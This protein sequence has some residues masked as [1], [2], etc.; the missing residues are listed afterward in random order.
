[1]TNYRIVP[2]GLKEFDYPQGDQNVYTKYAGH[3]GILLIVWKK[4]LLAWHQFDMR[5][6]FLLTCR[7]KVAFNCGARSSRVWCDLRPS[8]SSIATPYLVMDQGR[9]FWIQDAY[10]A[11]DG[12]PYSEPTDNGF[13]YIRNSVKIVV[14][15]Y[16]GDVDSYVVDP[17][18]PILR[19]YRAALPSPLPPTR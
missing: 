17:Q 14:D 5:S 19:V 12:F 1:M 8:L 11:A 18:D 4:A 15:A 6:F 13:S 2:T 7:R 16:E 3:G 10:T 9:L